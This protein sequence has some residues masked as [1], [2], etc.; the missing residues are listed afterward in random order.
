M[1]ED[2]GKER[3]AN[4]LTL[5]QLVSARSSCQTHQSAPRTPSSSWL[6][7]ILISNVMTPHI[8]QLLDRH[9]QRPMAVGLLATAGSSRIV[10]CVSQGMSSAG[11]HSSA[12][13]RWQRGLEPQRNPGPLGVPVPGCCS[14][15][16]PLIP[17]A[18]GPLPQLPD[19]G[20][21]ERGAAGGR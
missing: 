3:S 17:E 8:E 1:G 15:S 10:P 2:I 5:T 16:D 19:C 20:P 21:G 6:I 18:M 11:F 9:P 4:L 14:S 7:V 12:L 13:H